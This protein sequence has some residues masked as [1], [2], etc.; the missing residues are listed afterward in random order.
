MWYLESGFS[1][2]MTRNSSLL[3]DLI[4]KEGTN[5]LFGNNHY[6]QTK[7]YDTISNGVVSFSK[8]SLVKE[9]EHNFLWI[10]Q[11]CDKRFNVVF[12]DIKCQV[13][14]L[15]NNFIVLTGFRKRNFYVVNLTNLD[16]KNST[17]FIA[18]E[19]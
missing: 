4:T 5:V 3:K 19:K 16:I 12:F 15:L 9:L 1:R 13:F 8:V 14:D 11:L 7:G 17:C 18:S 2:H 10:S 6:G